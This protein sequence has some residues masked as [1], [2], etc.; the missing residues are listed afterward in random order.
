MK[1]SSDR[2]VNDFFRSSRRIE[3]FFPLAMSNGARVDGLT[4]RCAG[5][6]QT[7]LDV[8]GDLRRSLS[9]WRVTA[10]GYCRRCDL[11]TPLILEVVPAGDSYEVIRDEYVPWTEGK[12]IPLFR[13]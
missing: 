2:M 7:L 11:L 1:T 4:G 5:C 12:V 8:R 9:G 6:D 10:F 3:D 13:K